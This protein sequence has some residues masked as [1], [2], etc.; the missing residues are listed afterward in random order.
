MAPSR[1]RDSSITLHI[2]YPYPLYIWPCL[3]QLTN[4][5]S[6]ATGFSFNAAAGTGVKAPIATVKSRRLQRQAPRAVANCGRLA[7][8]LDMGPWGWWLPSV[9]STAPTASQAPT[10]WHWSHRHTRRGRHRRRRHTRTPA[11]RVHGS[12][13]VDGSACG[14][15]PARA[16]ACPPLVCSPC[17]NRAPVAR[18]RCGRCV[19]HHRAVR[20]PCPRRRRTMFLS[21][22]AGCSP[23]AAL[24]CDFRRAATRPPLRCAAPTRS[25][26]PGRPDLLSGVVKDPTETVGCG[27]RARSERGRGRGFAR[28]SAARRPSQPSQS[29]QPGVTGAD[30]QARQFLDPDDSGKR[31]LAC[32]HARRGTRARQARP[33]PRCVPAF[34]AKQVTLFDP[35]TRTVGGC[36]IATPLASGHCQCA[37]LLLQLHTQQTYTPYECCCTAPAQPGPYSCRPGPLTTAEFKRAS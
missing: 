33:F 8:R 29:R 35:G 20:R 30:V 34:P 22:R 13:G 6:N 10:A 7:V 27:R 23:A 9:R 14:A 12:H 24:P 16:A 17:S 32:R 26:R 28:H 5:R 31:S 36:G 11:A 37:R 21:N 3:V 1:A 2:S 25:R 4:C 15:A 18:R 19:P